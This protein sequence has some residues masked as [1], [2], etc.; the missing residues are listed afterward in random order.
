MTSRSRS[1]L[2]SPRRFL[3]CLAL[4][5]IATAAD[6]GDWRHALVQAVTVASTVD[7]AV[8]GDC[9]A[10]SDASVRVA[11]VSYR[12]GKSNYVRAVPIPAADDFAVHEEVLVD[13]GAC[14]IAHLPKPASRA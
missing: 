1:L 4:C 7:A 9:V 8:D 2:E 3:P 6:A 13:P 11:V 5:A 14:R 12:V 10:R